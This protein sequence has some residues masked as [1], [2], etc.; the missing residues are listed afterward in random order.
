MLL[1]VYVTVCVVLPSADV[2]LVSNVMF[3]PGS[4]SIL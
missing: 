4:T 2:H 1:T 3:S